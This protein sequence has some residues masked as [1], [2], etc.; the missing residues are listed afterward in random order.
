MSERPASADRRAPA[1]SASSLLA[2]SAGAFVA[3]LACLALFLPP[4][5]ERTLG[6]PLRTALTALVLAA[7]MALHWWWLGRAARRLGQ[8]VAAWVALAV[9]LFPLGSAA[10]LMLLG[11]AADTR[12]RA[13]HA[14]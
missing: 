5:A 6:A 2:A 9:L 8:S 11:G 1:A 13:V 12:R 4:L 14:V 3:A 10:A 7:A